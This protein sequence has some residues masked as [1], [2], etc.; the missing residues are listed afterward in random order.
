MRKMSFRKPYDEQKLS[1]VNYAED[2]SILISAH[3]LNE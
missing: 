3:N 2:F 1:R